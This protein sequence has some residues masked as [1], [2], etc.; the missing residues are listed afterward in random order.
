MLKTV[1]PYPSEHASELWVYQ[2]DSPIPKRV[3]GI[4]SEV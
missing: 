2:N 1:S 4:K 3:E